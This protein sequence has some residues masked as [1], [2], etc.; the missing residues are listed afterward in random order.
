RFAGQ[1]F[2]GRRHHRYGIGRRIRDGDLSRIFEPAVAA[3]FDSVI[4]GVAA[5]ARS[6]DVVAGHL[7]VAGN[8]TVG[9]IER[10]DAGHRVEIIPDLD[11][12]A[13]HPFDGGGGA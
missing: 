13:V 12:Y 4:D 8:I 2:F 7:D 3:V 9:I 10:I 5:G 11:I 6:V 1:L